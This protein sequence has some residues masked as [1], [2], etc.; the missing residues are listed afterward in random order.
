[1]ADNCEFS[2]LKESLIRIVYGIKYSQVKE[3]LLR[4]PDLTLRKAVNT[5]RA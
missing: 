3:R 2:A 4:V 5:V 1:M